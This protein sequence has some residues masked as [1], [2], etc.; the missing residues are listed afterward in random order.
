MQEQCSKPARHVSGPA[1]ASKSHKRQAEFRPRLLSE[2]ID[3]FLLGCDRGSRCNL[4]CQ[5]KQECRLKVRFQMAFRQGE[6]GFQSVRHPAHTYFVKLKLYVIDA[7]AFTACEL[8]IAGLNFDF[9]A[10]SS[11]A[12]RRN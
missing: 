4:A 5:R 8:N 7:V 9:L 10:A 11:A 2:I 12:P 3:T 6:P 1:L